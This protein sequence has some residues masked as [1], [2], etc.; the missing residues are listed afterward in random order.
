MPDN[1]K[2]AVI[3][4]AFGVG[5]GT[6]LNRSYRELARHYGFKIDPTPV[7]DP[8]KKGKVESSVKYVKGNFFRG[9]DGRPAD[10]LQGEL[11]RWVREIAGTR[12]HGT[13]GQRPLETFLA[14][15][16]PALLDLPGV[17]FEMVEW[18]EATV[19][20][21]SHVSFEKRLYSAPWRFIG[22]KVWLR[23]TAHTVAVYFDDVRLAT[24]DRRGPDL[25][26]TLDAHLPEHRSAYRHRSRDFW[27]ERADEIGA[28]VG[29]YVREVFDSDE[30]LSMLRVVQAIVTH[31]ERFPPERARAACRRAS[32]YG[33]RSYQ[34][35]K[36]IL[37]RALDLE[38]LPI[39]AAPTRSP[40]ES[41]RYARSATE[42]L[43]LP[44]ED[45]DEPN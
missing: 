26:S 9:Q 17:A 35:V 37:D 16:Q 38:P 24:H 12:E 39:A 19:H 30:V 43:N 45:I 8:R 36:N 3:R 7:Y 2:S 44:L 29:A 22:K 11:D 1:L 33:I 32:F 27:E 18:K 23:A 13:T 15:E 28:E 42:L 4:A 5:E 31:L 40:Q 14:W 20:Q 34:G 41:F 21:D 10:E 25:R 6:S